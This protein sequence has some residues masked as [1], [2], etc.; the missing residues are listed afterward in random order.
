MTG[1]SQ[2]SSNSFYVG[3]AGRTG[4]PGVERKETGTIPG[5][6]LAQRP[7]CEGGFYCHALRGRTRGPCMR[8]LLQN[9]RAVERGEY[10]RVFARCQA[11]EMA[12]ILGSLTLCRGS[13]Y[14]IGG[15][16]NSATVGATSRSKSE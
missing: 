9:P 14:P 11:P 4:I 13:V 5:P 16:A 2:T 3:G 1:H 8:S 6:L 7:S 12:G 15:S 10:A